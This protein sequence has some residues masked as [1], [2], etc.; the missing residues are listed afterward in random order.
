[1][2][3]S[4]EEKLLIEN[5]ILEELTLRLKGSGLYFQ[6]AI[7]IDKNT[8]G[9]QYPIEFIDIFVGSQLPIYDPLSQQAI[10]DQLTT[11]INKILET[12]AKT[13]FLGL[14]NA[15]VQFIEEFTDRKQIITLVFLPQAR[16]AKI[17]A[18]FLQGWFDRS[19]PYIPDISHLTTHVDLD[20]IKKFKDKEAG[21]TSW[22][23][24]LLKK[25]ETSYT[26]S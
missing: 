5:G 16:Y 9:E 10:V 8:Q 26:K 25:N 3:E 17:C 22:F 23:N 12:Q 18:D 15:R 7:R 4:L 13:S 2:I 24:S 20:L 14:N 6:E 19:M 1:M 11:G 21:L